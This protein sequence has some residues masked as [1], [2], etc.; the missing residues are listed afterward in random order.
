MSARDELVGVVRVVVSTDEPVMTMRPPPG[1][2]AV[3]SADRFDAVVL[4]MDGVMTDTATVHAAAW[5]R[6]FDDYLATISAG[7]PVPQAPFQEGDYL[8][9][10]DG[11]ARDDGVESFLASRGIVLARG[12]VDD[13]PEIDTA[14]GLAN[15]KNRY[16]QRVLADKGAHAFPTSVS[17]VKALQRAGVRTGI[18]SASR[19][20]QQVLDSAGIGDLF[21]VRIDGIESERLHLP[22]K[23]SP[24]V[25]IE[26]ARALGAEP[27]RAVV[28]EDAIA[29]VQAGR[30]G[31][32]GLVIGVDRTGQ[33]EALRVNGAEVVVGDLGELLVTGA[34]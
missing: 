12:S 14:W 23:P 3:V 29:G 1:A 6:M 10:V 4:D 7:S 9:Y 32:F 13:R 31:H 30:A 28:V 17:F 25:F 19:N 8:S 11:K 5:K 2:A 33:A 16:F 24:A 26:A 27:E 18:I 22:G 20:C 34:R 15:R 21:E